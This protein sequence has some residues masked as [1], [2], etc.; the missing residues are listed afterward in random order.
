MKNTQAKILRHHCQRWFCKETL[1][2]VFCSPSGHPWWEKKCCRDTSVSPIR[3]RLSGP[4]G[5]P[6]D[7]KSSLPSFHRFAIQALHFHDSV[8]PS[9]HWSYHALQASGKTCCNP[10]L[11]STSE[12]CHS[13]PSVHLW[14]VWRTPAKSEYLVKDGAS[15]GIQ[16]Q[17]PN[18]RRN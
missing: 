14:G 12:E 17:Q 2:A 10:A 4:R 16:D 8:S 3:E 15:G 13:L 11:N 5:I 7:P 1:A 9:E 18:S 6:G